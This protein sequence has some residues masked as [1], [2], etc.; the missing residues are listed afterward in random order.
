MQE[1][2]ARIS[3]FAI[4]RNYTQFEIVIQTLLLNVLNLWVQ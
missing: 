2:N 1:T 4:R 3:R